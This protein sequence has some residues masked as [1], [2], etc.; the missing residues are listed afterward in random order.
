MLKILLD[1]LLPLKTLWVEAL[2]ILVWRDFG[3][4]TTQK[5]LKKKKKKNYKA[6]FGYWK[7]WGKLQGKENREKKIKGNKKWRKIKN[8]FKIN[9]WFLYII[10]NLFYLFFLWNN[11]KIYKFFINF[12]YI[13][14]IYFIMKLNIRKL[15][16]KI[17]FFFP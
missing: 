5:Y 1:K 11:F 14:F 16:F 4:Q 6:M 13:L 8:K 15:F 2:L 7:I 12:N 3:N 10:S 17:L 9:K